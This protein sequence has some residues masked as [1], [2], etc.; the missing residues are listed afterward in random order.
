ME[1]STTS[2]TT[3]Q[4]DNEGSYRLHDDFQSAK[5][6]TNP[7]Q[8]LLLNLKPTIF[9]STVAK[10][11]HRGDDVEI[12]IHS[13]IA[14]SRSPSLQTTEAKFRICQVKT[15]NPRSSHQVAASH[16]TNPRMT[17]HEDPLFRTEGIVFKKIRRQGVSQS[18][19]LYLQHFMMQIGYAIL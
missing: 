9:S 4:G 12:T 7:Q 5:D 15:S 10:T 13:W 14:S 8:R 19:I 2:L 3:G 1:Q 6:R 18:H 17:F 16:A 11:L